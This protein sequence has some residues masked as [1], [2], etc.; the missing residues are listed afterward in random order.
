MTAPD[1]ERMENLL[2]L[3][4]LAYVHRLN[5]TA[6]SVLLQQAQIPLIER[7]QQSLI[8]HAERPALHL[9]EQSHQ[10]PPTARPQPRDPA[11]LAAIARATSADRGWSAS[12]CRKARRCSPGFWRS[13]AAARCIC[14]WNRAIRCSASNTSCKTR[15][16]CCCCM[17]A[18]I[19]LATTMAGL[20][21]SHIDSADADLS[22]ALMR[23]RPNSMRRAWR[24]TPRAPPAIR[25][26]CCSV[27]PTSRTSLRG[28]PTTCSCTKR[29]GCCSSR[30]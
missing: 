12:A 2:F 8:H 1:F 14:R 7:L 11:A 26:A 27:R 22:Q 9:A 19:R 25:K 10:L 17:M 18:S 21:V 6:N 28:T 29:A 30:R 16:R 20:D 5:D 23:H 15:A 13:S 4:S 24:S 3:D